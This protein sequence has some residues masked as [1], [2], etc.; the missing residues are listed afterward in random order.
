MNYVFRL[1]F[2][3]FVFVGCSNEPSLTFSSEVFTEENLEICKT[4]FCSPVSI[5]YV[6]ATGDAAISEKI[7]SEINTYIIDAL[8]LGEDDEPS[9]KDIP[10]ATTQFILAYRDHQPDLPTNLDFGGYEAE[11][12]AE[13][14]H[15]TETL[16][17]VE[18]HSYL[19]TGGAHGYGGTT[20]IMFDIETGERMSIENLFEDVPRFEAFA[21]KAFKKAYD[22]P[23]SDNINASGFWFDDDQF[24]LPEAVGIRENNLV[25]IYNAYEISSY[26]AGPIALE[27]PLDEIE[28]Y[29]NDDLI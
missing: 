28:S 2:V 22:I 9:A 5:N 26:A 4:E 17:C 16:V 15:Q 20:F 29:L 14:T 8:F 11:I 24:Y 6:K 18:F 7:N 27:I 21:E 19:F 12:N 23:L 13:I 1:L 25:L 3:A 10:Q